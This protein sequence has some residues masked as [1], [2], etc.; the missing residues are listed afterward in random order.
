L[1]QQGDRDRTIIVE[2][3]PGLHRLAHPALIGARHA[4]TATH[5]LIIRG[6]ADGSTV[7]RGSVPLTPLP[8]IAEPLAKRL[9][10]EA[11]PHVRAFAMPAG[12]PANTPSDVVR[13]FY[14]AAEPMP[15]E[16]FDGEGALWP[17]RWPN[18]GWAHT[19]S[20]ANDR[21]FGASAPNLAAWQ[22]E[23]ELWAGGYW[24]FDWAYETRRVAR[25]E[26]ASGEITLAP[27]P[28][29]GLAENTRYFVYNALCELDAAGEWYRDAATG[30]LLV[31]P[32]AEERASIE[33]SLAP[34][35]FVISGASDVRLEKLAIERFRGDAIRIANSQRVE[36]AESRIRWVAGRAVVINDSAA[37]GVRASTISDTG[38]GGVVLFGG[39]RA[40]LDAARLYADGNRFE[41]FSRLGHVYKPAAWI[42]GVGNSVT[43]NVM[44]DAPHSAIIFRGNDHLIEGNEIAEVATEASDAGAIYT[45]RDWTSRGTVIRQNYIHDVRASSGFEVKG[46][47]LDDMV[48]GLDIRGNLF[49]RVDQPVFIGGGRDNRVEDN[50]FIASSPAVHIDG[51][52]LTWAK[53]EIANAGSEIHQNLK[54]M[55]Y[56]S[57]VWR[58]RYPSLGN[59]LEDEPGQPKRNRTAGNLIVDGEAYQVLPEVDRAKQTIGPDHVVA[60]EAARSATSA[61]EAIGAVAP[62]LD[63]Q[64]LTAVGKSLLERLPGATP[65]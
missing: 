62:E 48:S 56:K 32:R 47:Y 4:G 37:S 55:P 57:V 22:R 10:P 12:I 20:V 17:A 26:G 60:S 24:H 14:V 64:G 59:I 15:F 35:A 52:G 5:P 9:P 43:R 31:W 63:R 33:V 44:R 16:V 11:L 27:A 29:F 21:S 13:V 54:R 23:P 50:I 39:N 65:R 41:R 8:K 25:V 7:L 40:T 19:V 6:A 28:K 30:T 61:A 42:D 2:L 46:I 45:G 49:L 53:N 38:E 1:R 3:G 36:V 51:R 18:S 58:T 34:S